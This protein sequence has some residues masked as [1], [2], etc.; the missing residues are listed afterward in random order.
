MDWRL[1]SSEQDL[2]LDSWRAAALWTATAIVKWGALLNF[3]N[4]APFYPLDGGRTLRAIATVAG[5]RFASRLI[6]ALTIL[7]GVIGLVSINLFLLLIAI[8]GLAAAR[9]EEALDRRLESISPREAVLAAAAYLT[10]LGFL[11]YFSLPLLLRFIPSL[12]Q[13]GLG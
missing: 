10:M 3:L 5:P 6:Y 9:Q 1:V 7:L 13:L 8:V 12:Q 4:L 2:S 11:G